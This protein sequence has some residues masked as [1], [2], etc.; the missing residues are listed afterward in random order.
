MKTL[1]AEKAKLRPLNLIK[2]LEAGNSVLAFLMP[3]ELEPGRNP[4]TRRHISIRQGLGL[5]CL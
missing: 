3:V 1:T 4:Q 2:M 5:C